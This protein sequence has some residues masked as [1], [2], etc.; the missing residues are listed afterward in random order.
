MI[1]HLTQFSVLI[2]PM[3]A[4]VLMAMAQFN[5]RKETKVTVWVSLMGMSSL[6]ISGTWAVNSFGLF[7]L[8]FAIIGSLTLMSVAYILVLLCLRRSIIVEFLRDWLYRALSPLRS[9]SRRLRPALIIA[10]ALL[11]FFA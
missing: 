10:P 7:G 1:S 11:F 8:I 6:L 2:L 4:F 9:F 3:Q 5:A